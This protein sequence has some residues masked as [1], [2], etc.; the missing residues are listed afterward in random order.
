MNGRENILQRIRTEIFRCDDVD[1]PPVPE[2][3][4]QT[5]AEPEQLVK[6]FATELEAVQGEMIRCASLED[7]RGRLIQLADEAEW[8]KIAAADRPVCRELADGLP[9]ERLCWEKADWDPQDMAEVSAGLLT[10]EWLLADTGSCVVECLTAEQRLLCYLPPA[11][12]VIAQ[13]GR[14]YEHMPAAWEEIAGRTAEPDRRG[15]FV[16]ITG[17]SRTADIEKIL[18]LGVHGPKRL[19][20]LLVDEAAVQQ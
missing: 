16:I 14:L 6:R 3:W 5:D 12:V 15:E 7:A 8:T 19:V 2:V 1:A 9:A 20:V 13:R 4:P 18:I 17:P 11:C 10:A